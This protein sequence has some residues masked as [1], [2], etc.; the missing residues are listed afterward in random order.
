M[1]NSYEE[2]KAGDNFEDDVDQDQSNQGANDMMN[3]PG[4]TRLG[5]FLVG[6]HVEE[7]DDNTG[8]EGVRLSHTYGGLNGIGQDER[9]QPGKFDKNNK[10]GR[11]N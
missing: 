6:E 7:E 5:Q 9:K 3:I 11:H 2:S 1:G 8:P 4:S 10:L